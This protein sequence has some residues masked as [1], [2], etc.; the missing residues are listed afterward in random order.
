VRGW[1]TSH[2]AEPEILSDFY[3]LFWKIYNAGGTLRPQNNHRGQERFLGINC[4]IFVDNMNYRYWIDPSNG[5]AL[6]K[7]DASGRVIGFEVLEYNLNFTS[8]PAGLPP[9]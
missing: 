4:D 9:R 1:I 5:C 6:K 8:W 3:T 7:T 2:L